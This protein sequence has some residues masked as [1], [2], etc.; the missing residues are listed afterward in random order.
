MCVIERLPNN[1]TIKIMQSKHFI[2][3]KT[4][5]DGSAP[6]GK[7]ALKGGEA[8]TGHRELRCGIRPYGSLSPLRFVVICSF[9][10]GRMLLSY[11]SAHRSWETQGGH[12][13]KGETPE[14]AAR[15]EL[16]EESGAADAELIPVCDYFAYDSEGSSNG[17]VFAAIVHRLDRLPPSEMSEVRTFDAF[18]DDLTYPFVTPVLFREAKR[19][20]DQSPFSRGS[21]VKAQYAS[22]GNLS[23]RISIHAKYSVNKQG[24]GNWIAEHYPISDG[25]RVLELGC[26][27]GENWLG[28]GALIE[29]C[30]KMILTDLSEGMLAKAKDTLKRYSGIEYAVADIQDIP[31]P[32][33]SFDVVIANMMLYHVPDIAAGLSEVRRVLR[34]GGTFCCATFGENGIMEYLTGLFG[35]KEEA[36]HAFTLQNGADRLREFFDTVT[37]YDYHDSL[38]VTDV[39]DMADYIYSLTGMSSLRAVPRETVV[40]VLTGA[41]ENGVL[42]V[43]KEYGLFLSR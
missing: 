13:E 21:A 31:C 43:P 18:P 14:E 39:N 10:G 37:R 34:P 26:G 3:E 12:I 8:M 1:N 32:D 40:K 24:F 16:Y 33:R 30:S 38:E 15:R 5:R 42:K 20:T 9:Y 2:R 17:R 7:A 11:H 29:K 36:N 27:T 4:G 28:Q 23:A 22:P 25:A 35:V 19:K 41:M 6:T